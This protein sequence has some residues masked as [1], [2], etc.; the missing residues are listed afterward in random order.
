MGVMTAVRC[1]ENFK[2]FYTRLKAKGNR[3]HSTNYCDEKDDYCG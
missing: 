1:D 2:A 3:Q